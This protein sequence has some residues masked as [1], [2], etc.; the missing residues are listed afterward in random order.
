[1]A[2]AGPAGHCVPDRAAGGGGRSAPGQPVWTAGRDC[3][4]SA[5]SDR[6]MRRAGSGG[7]GESGS[8]VGRGGNSAFSGMHWIPEH[9]SGPDPGIVAGG[10]G[11]A[12]GA[13]GGAW[14]FPSGGELKPAP[15]RMKA[16]WA[17][18][19][20]GARGGAALYADADF[21]QAIGDGLPQVDP[22]IDGLGLGGPRR[23]VH[24]DPGLLQHLFYAENMITVA[25]HDATGQVAALHD[26]ADG[27]DAL[28]GAL[29]FRL[30]QN[31]L[32]GNAAPAQVGAPDLAFGIDGVA[33][34]AAG[35]E[36]ERREAAQVEEQRVVEARLEH[37]RR[38]AAI[39]GGAQ[40]DNDVSRLGLVSGGL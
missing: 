1:M 13:R 25:H 33:A 3:G 35:G 23:A 36:D 38:A 31:G 15:S 30:D 39:F 16:G 11:A 18:G 8:Q 37:R 7:C 2:G 9:G 26:F 4:R 32:G 19:G 20:D 14:R 24:L 27:G 29:A 6:K 17:R 40:D 5:L 34:G 28:G 21:P 22:V 10:T 12:E